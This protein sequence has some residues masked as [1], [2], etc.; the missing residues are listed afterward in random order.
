MVLIPH[1]SG[2]PL[3]III[4][5]YFYLHV[6][7]GTVRETSS[8]IMRLSHIILLITWICPFRRDHFLINDLGFQ[9]YSQSRQLLL[10]PSTG[11]VP[12]DVHV[13]EIPSS[14]SLS[15]TS[16]SLSTGHTEFKGVLPVICLRC[17]TSQNVFIYSVKTKNRILIVLR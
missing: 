14:S 10:Y 6:N 5:Y 7:V 3:Y 17:R 11:S 15:H 4:S 12:L 13:P 9:Y 2:R 1:C 16:F 8:I